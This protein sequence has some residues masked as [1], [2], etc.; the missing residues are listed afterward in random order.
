MMA[1]ARV[2][3]I[4]EIKRLFPRDL[5]VVG[6]GVT[7]FQRTNLGWLLPD[8]EILS[9]LETAD[10]ELIRKEM[11]VKSVERDLGGEWPEKYNTSG[12]LKM[13]KV[14]EYLKSKQGIFVYKASKPIDRLVGELGLKLLSTPGAIRMKYENKKE[15]RVEAEKAGIRIPGGETLLVDELDEKRWEKFRQ[16]WGGRLVFQLTDYTIGGGLGTFFINND[17]DFLEFKDFVK[18]R[19]AVRAEEGKVIEFVNVCERVEGAAA[20]I[21]GCATKYGVVTGILQTQIIDQPELAALHGRSGV[22]LGHDWN[23]R[24]SEKAQMSAEKLCQQWGEWIYKGGYKGIFGLDVVVTDK[25]EV[26][27]IECNARYTGAFPVYT[28]MQLDNKE[29]PIDVWHLLEW[30]RVDYEMDLKK[31][32]K[33]ARQSKSGAHVIMHNLERK[34][35]TATKTVKPGVY[36]IE[37]CIRRVKSVKGSKGLNDIHHSEIGKSFELVWLREGFSLMDIKS[38]DEMVLV[39]RVPNE[40][41]V[42]KPAERVGKLLFKRRIID[43]KG[44]LLPEIQAVIKNMY[45]KFELA[46]VEIGEF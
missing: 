40:S 22:W 4:Y 10:L 5:S 6:V 38:K 33:V 30:T 35:V 19:R 11:K 34:T 27:V 26:A 39:D 32:Q 9:L 21:T 36:R 46:V 15:F 20:S 29:M 2:D 14:R 28:M 37:P 42:L 31:V 43:D 18:R 13:K 41:Q 7:G 23:V 25:D 8:Y 12:I 24:F 44:R 17:K 3:D 16:E 1:G 45:Q